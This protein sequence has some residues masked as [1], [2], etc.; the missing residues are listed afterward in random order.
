MDFF[1]K[2]WNSNRGNIKRDVAELFSGTG[3]ECSGGSCVIGCAY[4]GTSCSSL[5]GSYGVNWVTF[6]MNSVL[7]STLVSHEIGHTLGK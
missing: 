7:Q 2:Y 4:V 3:L 1:Q 5:A 6:N